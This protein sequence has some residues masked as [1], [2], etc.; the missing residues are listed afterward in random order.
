MAKKDLL[1]ALHRELDACRACPGVIGPVVHGPPV[2]SRILLVGQAPGP[3]EGRF[4]RPF[5][6]TAGKTMFGWF[7]RS[8]GLEEEDFRRRVYIAAVLRCFPG[9]APGG[10]DRKPAPDE[11]ARCGT[12]LAREV[13]LLEPEL[14]IPVGT[15]AIEQVMGHRGPLVEVVGKTRRLTFHGRCPGSRSCRLGGVAEEIH[16]VEAEGIGRLHAHLLRLRRAV[17]LE[18]HVQHEGRDAD[19]EDS[20]HMVCGPD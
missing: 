12:F 8:L 10:G 1:L 20:A 16:V 3:R 13:A 7:Q 11:I 15:M 9:K 17:G 5:A 19:T 14:V 4:G 18:R 6:W 2:R